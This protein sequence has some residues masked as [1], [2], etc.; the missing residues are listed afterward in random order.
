[1]PKP[2][3]SMKTLIP[4]HRLAQLCAIIT[5]SITSAH[6]NS[7]SEDMVTDDTFFQELPQVLT[8]TRL[9]QP[10]D[11]APAAV[12]II[13]RDMIRASG[14]RTLP[15]LLR[16]V[17]GFSVGWM[18]GNRAVATYHG[19]S[20]N[21]P[22]R[23]Q[24]LVDGRSE[25]QPSLGGPDWNDLPV[26]MED[27]ARIEIVRGPNAA[28]YG[29][30]S[31]QAVINIITLH[32]AETQGV[33]TR[34]QLGNNGIADAYARAGSRI[35]NTDLRA[36][37]SY[38]QDN[39][40]HNNKQWMHDDYYRI[41]T[42]SLRADTRLDTFN[43]LMF[44]AGYSGGAR[45]QAFGTPNSNSP[46]NEKPQRYFGQ[47]RWQQ[48]RDSGEMISLQGVYNTVDISADI[49]TMINYPP[50]PTFPYRTDLGYKAERYDLEFQHTKPV[51]S[52]FR[53]VWGLGNRIDTLSSPA[54]LGNDRTHHI[55]VQRLFGNG[56]YRLTNDLIANAG[57]MWEHNALAGTTL[58]PRAALNYRLFEGHTLRISASRGYRSPFMI[59]Q[60]GMS[61]ATYDLP[62][63]LPDRTDTYAISAGNVAPETI[64]AYELGYLGNPSRIPLNVELRL[65]QEYVD[66]LI[67]PVTTS[68]C[69]VSD[70]INNRCLVIDN[71]D[72]AIIRGLESQLRY[73]LGKRSWLMINHALTRIHSTDS[74]EDYQYSRSAPRHSGTI[75]LVQQL[76]AGIQASAIY[77][78]ASAMTWMGWDNKRSLSG[79]ER[80]DLRIAKHYEYQ[81][82]QFDVAF[83]IQIA[84]G[85]YE[86]FNNYNLFTPRYLFSIA[87]NYK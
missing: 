87:M 23:M 38:A 31:F 16:L 35:G 17:P 34:L 19:L 58:S 54:W 57:A 65:F 10:L 11:E 51:T 60:Y 45:G 82:Q 77:Y 86:D 37:F 56:E 14:A 5:V 43:S 66:R 78:R 73:T 69:P 27:I 2:T 9:E 8:A 33:G 15:D 70:N 85:R 7:I 62:N 50:I 84:F 12:T 71:V 6:A 75:M 32:A 48:S 67:T 41:P 42:V 20:D 79:Y 63:P 52:Q 74:D 64:N 3:T 29:S 22:R 59:E 36:S 28:S 81:N 21:L 47:I 49:A 72:K 24:V 18:S 1:M 4:P 13:D 30:N 40:F 55:H 61:R 53:L 44:N 68:P 25:Y 39:G 76:P 46:Y 83:T 26:S 80:F